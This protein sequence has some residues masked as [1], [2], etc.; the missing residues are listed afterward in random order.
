MAEYRLGPLFVVCLHL[1]LRISEALALRWEDVDPD[2]GTIAVR[3]TAS[4]PHVRQERATLAAAIARWTG[5]E[6]P[7]EPTMPRRGRGRTYHSPKSPASVRTWPLPPP[8]LAAFRAWR[9][10]SDAERQTAGERW[11]DSGRVFATRD[12]RPLAYQDVS[13]TWH[14]LLRRAGVPSRGLHAERHTAL[15]RALQD[16]LTPVEVAAMAGHSH[17]GVTLQIYAHLLDT[18]HAEAARKQAAGLAADPSPYAESYAETPETGC[19]RD[20][21]G[22]HPVGVEIPKSLEHKALQDTEAH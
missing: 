12:G 11:T 18:S 2:A 13:D 8:T 14:A 6:E 7:E 20:D 5:A 10:T 15:S 21:T 4:E 17:P 22:V 3:Q 19:I 9:A 1:G 16:G